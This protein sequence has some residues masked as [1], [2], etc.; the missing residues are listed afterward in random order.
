[1]FLDDS[2]KALDT[3]EK[4]ME[5]MDTSKIMLILFYFFHKAFHSVLLTSPVPF[6]CCVLIPNKWLVVM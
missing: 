4:V 3:Q 1:M 2:F 6:S 5:Y